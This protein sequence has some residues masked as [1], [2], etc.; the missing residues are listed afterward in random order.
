MAAPAL[1]LAPVA[2][3]AAPRLAVA[4]PRARILLTTEGTYPYALGGVSSWCDLLL[5]GLT[6]FEWTVLPIIAPHGRAPLYELP[7]NAREAG[8]IEVW[9][10]TVPRGRRGRAARPALPGVLVRGLLGWDGDSAAVLD[11]WLWCRRDPAG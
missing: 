5:R 2:A 8:P 3:D 4:T 7:G 10:E 1:E 11:E 6:E 9:S